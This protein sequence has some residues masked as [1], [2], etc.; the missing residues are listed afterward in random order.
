MSS[1]TETL[2]NLSQY[3]NS[4]YRPGNRI[5]IFVWYF[6]NAC[7][8]NTSLIPFSC[9]KVFLLRLFGAKIGQR[10]CVKPS[11]S[12]KYPWFLTVG[13]NVWIGENVWIDNL[14]QVTIGNNVCISQGAYLCC[15][16]H[17]YKKRGFDLMLGKI[18]LK[19]GCW[20][21]AGAKICPGV[22]ANEY[23]ILGVGSVTSK[24]L[25]ARGIYRGNP[26]MKIGERIFEGEATT[27]N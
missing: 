25:E 23:S 21:C 5:K 2:T 14:A 19:E 7:I 8:L 20:I 1:G 11:V 26:A 22:T 3:D 12:V 18:T 24:D 16:N 6:T 10:V 27:D 15:G 17:N 13:D 9:L 4:W